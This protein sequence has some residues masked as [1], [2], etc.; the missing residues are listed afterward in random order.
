MINTCLQIII[1]MCISAIIKI[2]QTLRHQISFYYVYTYIER[3][4]QLNCA[5]E[6]NY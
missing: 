5:V 1:I 2:N 3:E 6:K 4:E